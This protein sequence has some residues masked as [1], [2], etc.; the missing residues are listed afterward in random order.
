MQK[1]ISVQGR[2]CSHGPVLV[3]TRSFSAKQRVHSVPAHF[4]FGLRPLGSTMNTKKVLVAEV[5]FHWEECP[6]RFERDHIDNNDWGV[7]LDADE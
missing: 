4:A 6:D 2:V 3:Q 5:R 7:C 1:S